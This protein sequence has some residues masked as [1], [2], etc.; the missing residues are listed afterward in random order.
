MSIYI[1]STMSADVAYVGFMS[2]PAGIKTP[3]K[4]IIIAGKANV[5]D[6]RLETPKGKVTEVSDEDYA[7]LQE[8]PLFQ[9]HQ[10]NGFIKIESRK[11]E[12]EKVVTADMEAKDKSAPKTKTDYKSKKSADGTTYENEPTIGSAE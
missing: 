12:V 2:S 10:K 6:K 9:L 5:A 3:A 4:R 8:I 7:V 11:R 1:Y